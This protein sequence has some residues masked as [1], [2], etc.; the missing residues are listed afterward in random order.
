MELH[1]ISSSSYGNGYV[2][3]SKDTALIIEC[4]MPLLAVKK[5]LN[6]NISKVSGVLIT[7]EHGDHAGRIKEYQHNGLEV[8]A[9][10]GTFDA[11]GTKGNN[12][13][14]KQKIS[15]GEFEV[16]PFDIQHDCAEPLGFIISHPDMGNMLF[17]TDTYYLKYTFSELN[18]IFIECNYSNDELTQNVT[19]SKLP[20][21]V[22]KRIIQSHFSLENVVGMLKANDLSNV[23]NVVLLHISSTNSNKES[24][25]REV[26]KATGT[27]VKIAQKG[28]V[29]NLR[30]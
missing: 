4:G 28:A 10:K 15:I 17:A 3:Q 27:L 12:L 24:M 23:R 26:Q 20:L 22:Q 7:H 18:H 11:L 25:V 30:L 14:A 2:L 8:Y 16:L 13:K 19:A 9:S 5:A 1:V 6:F 29:I 21:K